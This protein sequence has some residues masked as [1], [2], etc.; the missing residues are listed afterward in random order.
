[1]HNDKYACFSMQEVRK[2]YYP[3]E[4]VGPTVGVQFKKNEIKLSAGKIDGWIFES[5]PM[6]VNKLY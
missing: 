2:Y 3:S 1:M 6:K 4:Y 5:F